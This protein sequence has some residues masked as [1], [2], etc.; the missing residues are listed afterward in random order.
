MYGP[1]SIRKVVLQE[2][3]HYVGL[4]NH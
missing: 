2:S 4:R 3:V 1:T